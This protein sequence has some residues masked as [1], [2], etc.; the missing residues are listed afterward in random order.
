[1]KAVRDITK[2]GLA[3]SKKLVEDAPCPIAEGVSKEEAERIKEALEKVKATV[4]L[5]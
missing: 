5:D 2:L 1:M 3:E 4:K